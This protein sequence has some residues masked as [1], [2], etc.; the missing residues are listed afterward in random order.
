VVSV[1]ALHRSDLLPHHMSCFTRNNV[2][3]GFEVFQ[4]R[5]V[6]GIVAIVLLNNSDVG[7][8]RSGIRPSALENFVFDGSRE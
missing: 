7:C 8:Q 2:R 3:I 5:V 4:R 6:A 1:A